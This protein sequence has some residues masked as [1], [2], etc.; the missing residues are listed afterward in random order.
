MSVGTVGLPPQLPDMAICKVHMRH[1]IFN[2][3][4]RW[5]LRCQVI[6]LSHP[7][8][9]VILDDQ[10]LARQIL[11]G[12]A[13]QD[14]NHTAYPRGHRASSSKSDSLKPNTRSIQ[15]IQGGDDNQK[16]DSY[17]RARSSGR[18]DDGGRWHL[19]ELMRRRW[20][21]HGWVHGNGNGRLDDRD[22][23]RDGGQAWSL[24]GA[25]A[26]L[27]MVLNGIHSFPQRR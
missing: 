11:G 27:Y 23:W 16:Y 10:V 19:S 20:Q 4:H 8:T 6:E 9:Q 24:S 12:L 26:A 14:P 2:H 5:I 13:T 15:T 3:H 18:L 7:M 1:F 25:A 21:A 17:A 22:G